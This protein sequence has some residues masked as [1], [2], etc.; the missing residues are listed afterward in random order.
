MGAITDLA[1]SIND[2]RRS[3]WGD[4][5]TVGKLLILVV[6]IASGIGIPVIIIALAAQAIAE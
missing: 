2:A 4:A 6:L 5:S 1:E 3:I